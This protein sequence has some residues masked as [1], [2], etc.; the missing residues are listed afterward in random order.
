MSTTQRISAYILKSL[1]EKLQPS[2]FRVC[3]GNWLPVSASLSALGTPNRPLQKSV[4]APM[5]LCSLVSRA[6]QQ[7]ITRSVTTLTY[8]GLGRELSPMLA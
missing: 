1:I 5:A 4:S 3:R 8:Y 6:N 7:P 2:D